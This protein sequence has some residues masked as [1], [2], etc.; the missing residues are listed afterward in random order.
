[1]ISST[2][3]K[4]SC[5]RNPGHRRDVFEPEKVYFVLIMGILAFSRLRAHTRQ[6][7]SSCFTFRYCANFVNAHCTSEIAG[8]Q[9]RKQAEPRRYENTAWVINRYHSHRRN[10]IVIGNSCKNWEVRSHGRWSGCRTFERTQTES[11]CSPSSRKEGS[12]SIW[13]Q[14]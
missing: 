10:S 2:S 8:R 1:M 14:A 5:E 12:I 13:S 4:E 3:T 11:A 7:R 6:A 9:A